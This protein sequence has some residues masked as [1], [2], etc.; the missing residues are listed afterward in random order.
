MIQRKE[1]L[2]WRISRD[3]LTA[4]EVAGLF[5]CDHKTVSRWIN[6][7]WLRGKR[8]VAFYADDPRESPDPDRQHW[9]ISYK[10]LRKFM[11]HHP[12]EW[13]HRRVRKEVLLDI[14]IGPHWVNANEREVSNG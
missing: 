8:G 9:A 6:N 3:T 14:L 13:D 1:T 2:R 10:Q 11:L 12:S 7:G 4:R 5:G